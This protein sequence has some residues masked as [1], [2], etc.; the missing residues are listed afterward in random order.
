M[1]KVDET[2]TSV[3]N[4]ILSGGISRSK[5]RNLSPKKYFDA[6]KARKEILEDS[7]KKK[8]LQTELFKKARKALKDLF[9]PKNDT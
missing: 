2:E 8:P 6:D 4:A 5:D 3:M 1:R 7:N 9:T